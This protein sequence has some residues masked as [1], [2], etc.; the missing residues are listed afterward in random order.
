[1]TLVG[2]DE[3]RVASTPFFVP[4]QADSYVQG[5]VAVAHVISAKQGH[6]GVIGIP[7]QKLHFLGGSCFLPSHLGH[8]PIHWEPLH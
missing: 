1:M 3:V 2:R 7:L 4:H 6:G 5:P 8:I